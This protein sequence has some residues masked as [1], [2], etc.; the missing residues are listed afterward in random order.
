MDGHCYACK[1]PI[2][3]I[4]K[5]KKKSHILQDEWM[6]ARGYDECVQG[7]IIHMTQI[8]EQ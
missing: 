4:V 2:L 1:Q 7:Q 8:E 5:K 6:M 3:D